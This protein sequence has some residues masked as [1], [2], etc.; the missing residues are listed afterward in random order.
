MFGV[1]GLAAAVVGKQDDEVA[2]QIGQG[3]QA[4]GNQR[5]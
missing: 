2:D 3:V 1:S 4:I 5:L